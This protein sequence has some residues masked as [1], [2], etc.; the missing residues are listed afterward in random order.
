[1][2][3]SNSGIIWWWYEFDNLTSVLGS[4][5]MSG[6]CA[7]VLHWE[8]WVLAD[9]LSVNTSLAVL[10]HKYCC[11]A[12]NSPKTHWTKKFSTCF[13]FQIKRHKQTIKQDEHYLHTLVATVTFLHRWRSSLF[14]PNF[15]C[16]GL[17]GGYQGGTSTFSGM[18][19]KSY[20][21]LE[22]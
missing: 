5:E 22:N 10:V 3:Q 7:L 18:N 1:M 9:L 17:T 4:L 8:R 13:R 11:S 19:R 6:E 12:S 16:H 14:H 21:P 20:E 2:L 15:G